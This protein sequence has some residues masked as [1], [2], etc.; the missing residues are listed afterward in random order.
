M[1]VKMK[2]EYKVATNTDGFQDVCLENNFSSKGHYNFPILHTYL[3]TSN[4]FKITYDLYD[5][6]IYDF[7]C[8]RCF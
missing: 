4:T 8:I 1:G 2:T 7:K 3:K 5:I 6:H